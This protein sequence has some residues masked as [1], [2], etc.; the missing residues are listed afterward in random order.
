MNIVRNKP[1]LP[2]SVP[3]ST[4][5]GRNRHQLD[6]RKSRVSE[7]MMISNR[8]NHIPMLPNNAIT[9]TNQTLVRSFFDH[10]NCGAIALHQIMIQNDQAYG[11]NARFQK[12]KRSLWLPLY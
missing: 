7:V 12:P 10:M 11:P 1:K 3:K 6:G 5:V 2:A 8:S 4:S 9:K